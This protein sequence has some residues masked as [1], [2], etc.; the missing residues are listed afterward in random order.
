MQSGGEPRR[1]DQQWRRS[2]TIYSHPATDRI[3]ETD[4]TATIGYPRNETL[5]ALFIRQVKARPNAPAARL[6]D[7][8]LSY[9]ELD[10]AA[11]TLALRLATAGVKPGDVVGLL[12]HRSLQSVIAMVAVLK[13]GAAYAPLDPQY[14]IERL[15]FMLEDAGATAVLVH[16]DHRAKAAALPAFNG[17]IVAFDDPMDLGARAETP[18]SDGGATATDRAYVIYT[19]GS[20]GRPKGVECTHRGL[21]RMAFAKN[22]QDVA[23]GTVTLHVTSLSFDVSQYEFW[24]TLLNGGCLAILPDAT[25]A[26]DRIA[27]AIQRHN[28]T[29]ACLS[30]GLFHLMVDHRLDGL[31]PLRRIMVGGDVMSPSHVA[32]AAAA[33]T[34]TQLINGYGPTEN[35]VFTTRFD[36]PRAGWTDGAIPIGRGLE[37]TTVH[38]LD[39]DLKPVA[40][41]E[42]GQL[43]SGGDGVAMG[44]LNR[45][46]LTAEKFP[47]DPFSNETG[48]RLYLTG[49][50]VRMRPD[51]LIEF[52]GRADRQ[53]KIN[54]KRIELDEIENGLREDSDLADAAVTIRDAGGEAKRITAYL[55]PQNATPERER[56]AFG[57]IIIGRFKERFPAHMIPVDVVVLDAFPLTSAGKVDRAKL[58]Q[59]AARTRHSAPA[60]ALRTEFSLV[61][62]KLESAIADIWR[63]VL[64]IDHVGGN[65]SFFDLGGTSLLLVKVHAQIQ[66]LL[67][68][69]VELVTLFDKTTVRDLAVALSAAPDESAG[70]DIANA[71][72][73]RADKRAEAL[74]RA[75]KMKTKHNS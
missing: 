2:S 72:A 49:D 50:L 18:P 58:P 53:V 13:A 26:L 28:V 17:A 33:L 11:N 20:T 4:D 74:A 62:S 6:D 59:P 64:K 19:S 15:A 75:R 7:D 12:T 14:P 63:R 16:D 9:V 54:G 22:S 41:G 66:D 46:E 43:C 44:Y 23:P 60:S 34:D 61:E 24:V 47:P 71:Q 5:H 48:A 27:D 30:T 52:H 37:H 67:D 1:D 73:S 29:F 38:I 3:P 55:K 31:K 42:I 40:P 8:V 45:P 36:L 10:R 69:S 25:P 32:K 21:V 57:Q 70:R 56:D 68:S 65:D 51:G 39:K 35:A